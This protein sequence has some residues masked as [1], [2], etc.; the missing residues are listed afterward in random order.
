VIGDDG[1]AATRFESVP[2]L[3]KASLETAQLIVHGNTQSLEQA[4]KVPGSALWTERCP[5]GVHHII[6]GGEL[7][8]IST[9]CDLNGNPPS[10]SF[11]SVLAE[12]P[13][14][15]RWIRGID[16]V[17]GGTAT[18]THSH[19]QRRTGTEGKTATFLVQLP[20]RDPEVQQNEFGAEPG[21]GLKRLRGSKRGLNVLH[22]DVT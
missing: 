2:E 9:P 13:L 22:A 17:G 5:D 6:A 14:Q 18:L 12:Y 19:V 15:R 8:A 10:P 11:V 16:Q 21:N 7:A 1:Q 20:R 4:G 3:R